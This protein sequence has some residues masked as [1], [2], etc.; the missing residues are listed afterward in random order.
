MPNITVEFTGRTL[1]AGDR[2]ADWWTL[3]SGLIMPAP[4]GRGCS[5]RRGLG[6]NAVLNRCDSLLVSGVWVALSQ[7]SSER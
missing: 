3:H 1:L 4:I 2:V 6:R 7:F 5:H